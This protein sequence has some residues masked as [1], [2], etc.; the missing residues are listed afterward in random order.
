[1]APQSTKQLN[2]TLALVTCTYSTARAESEAWHNRCI[3]H[4]CHRLTTPLPWYFI[5]HSIELDT[6]NGFLS[7]YKC[8]ASPIL[9][10]YGTKDSKGTSWKQRSWLCP[11]LG[12][13]VICWLVSAIVN[14]CTESGIPKFPIQRHRNYIKQ[15]H[16]GQILSFR[17]KQAS[18]LVGC[19]TWL[20]HYAHIYFHPIW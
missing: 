2:T 3:W 20:R 4:H 14:L 8:L 16:W 15:V 9:K 12:R 5:T 1:M 11:L 19:Q 18:D 13:F 7:N 10:S 17:S 6:V